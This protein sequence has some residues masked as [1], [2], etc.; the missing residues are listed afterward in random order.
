[1]TVSAASRTLVGLLP[2][3]ADLIIWGGYPRISEDPDDLRAGVTRQREDITTGVV[4]RG[5][6]PENIVWFEENDTGAYKKKRI[7]VQDPMGNEYFGYRVIRP[8]WHSAL[9]ALRTREIHA[10]MVWDLDRLA[11]DPR[12]LE[13]AIECVQYYNARIEGSLRGDINLTSDGGIANARMLVVMAAKASADTS[14]RVKRATLAQAKTGAPSTSARRPF[15]WNA[16]Q[17]TLN[18]VE[19][20]AVRQMVERVIAGTTL[21]DVARD[22]NTAG[23]TTATGTRWTHKTVGQYL[24]NPRLVGYRTHQRQVLLDDNGKPVMG[25]WQPMVDEDTWDRLCLAVTRPHLTAGTRKGAHR[26]LLSGLMWCT[27]CGARMFANRNSTSGHSYRCKMAGDH[28]VTISGR[29]SD[30]LLGELIVAKLQSSRLESK[31]APWVGAGELAETQETLREVLE[32]YDKK[33]MSGALA[34]PRIEKAEQRIAQLNKEREAYLDSTAG[35]ALPSTLTQAQWDAMGFDKQRAIA[36]KM[37]DAILVTRNVT[38]SL[39]R[40]DANRIEPVWSTPR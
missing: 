21:G 39:R 36:E 11:R 10:L 25:T 19:A 7:K 40:F 15:G 1:M 30:R 3:P 4:A 20:A 18:P 14:R 24:R 13:D 37:L 12:D 38:P 17:L 32:A 29:G 33:Q 6:R 5:G 35:P 9:H 31:V 34:F 16:D 27:T 8:V 26:Y 22:L 2:M 28:A 23:T